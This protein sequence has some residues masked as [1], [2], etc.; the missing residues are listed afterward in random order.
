[1]NVEII[2]TCLTATTSRIESGSW[3][4]LHVQLKTARRGKVAGF[5]NYEAC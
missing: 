4:N 5:G 1:M 3:N 2:L